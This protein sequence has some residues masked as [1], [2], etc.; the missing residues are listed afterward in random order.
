M[1]KKINLTLRVKKEITKLYLRIYYTFE[2]FFLRL[3][4][5][6]FKKKINNNKSIISLLCPTKNRYLKFKRFT[7]SLINKTNDINRIELLICLTLR[8]EIEKYESEILRLIKKLIV[9]KFLKI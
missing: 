9:K 3:Y 4:Y 1:K 5:F 8:K 2:T 6:K 7:D